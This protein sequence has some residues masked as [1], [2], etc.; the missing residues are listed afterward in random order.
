VQTVGFTNTI[1]WQSHFGLWWRRVILSM[2]RSAVGCARRGC[3]RIRQF[4]RPVVDDE[5]FPTM[6]LQWWS[7]GAQWLLWSI[8]ARYYLAIYVQSTYK[9]IA[10]AIRDS[11]FDSSIC[12]TGW[13]MM[14]I[15]LMFCRT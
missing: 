1:G 8:L 12:L 6:L 9:L 13:H 5:P 15:L 7:A 11:R 4:P 10:I 3:Q 2:R 14:M